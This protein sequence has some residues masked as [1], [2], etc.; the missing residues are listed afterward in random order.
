LRKQL[1]LIGFLFFFLNSLL[2]QQPSKIIIEHADFGDKNDYELPDATLLT[3][4]VRANHDGAILTCNKAY[5]YTRENYIKAFGNVQITQ[6]D[7][8]Y[9]NG[10]YAEYNGN[11]RQAYTT[12]NVSLRSPEMSLVTDKINFDRNSQIAYYDT[13]GT[14]V[15]KDNTLTSNQGK[16]YVAQKKYQFLSSVTITNPKNVIKSNHLDYYTNSGHTYLYGPSTITGKDNF[17]YTEKGFYDTKS[18]KAHFVK[19]S[20]IKYKD[21]LI[22]GDSLYYDRNREFASATRNVKITDSINKAII[23]GHYGEVYRNKD[24]LYITKRASVRYLIEKDSMFIHAKRIVVTGKQTE[25]IVRG[26]NNVRFFKSDMSGKCDSLHSSQKK[27]LTQLIGKPILW[28]YD[29][30]LTGDLMHLI[31]NN[32]TEKLDSLKVLNNAFIASKDSLGTGYNQVKG[33]NLYGKFKDNKLNEVDMIKNTEVIYYM[34]DEDDQLIGINKNVSSKINIIFDKDKI[35]T[36][37]FFKDVDGDIYPEKDLPENARKLRGFNWR[38]EERI[39]SKE[40]IY[41]PEENQYDYEA[42]K[43]KKKED[44]LPEAPMEVRKETLEYDK[45]NPPPKKTE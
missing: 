17:I 12:G 15:N 18:N 5:Y 33:Q 4:N 41:P 27:A 28:N 1:F 31:G 34:R 10:D 20:Y 11:V 37:T 9:L 39:K 6:G 32:K 35:D 13:F 3:G 19:N 43:E 25:R 36:I 40:E 26:Y 30:Q 14:I 38:G 45:N 22:K 42:Q 21:R 8:L 44:S 16:Y 29:N 24:S 2:A 7:T 23:K